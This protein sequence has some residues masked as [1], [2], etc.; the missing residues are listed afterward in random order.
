MRFLINLFL[1]NIY[2][3]TYSN[4]ISLSYGTFDVYL[5]EPLE[6]AEAIDACTVMDG[7]LPR[8]N[9]EHDFEIIGSLYSQY[10]FVVTWVK[11]IVV[12]LNK[13]IFKSIRYLLWT[14]L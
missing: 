12:C 14:A 3:Q 8:F 2:C 10:D 5:M 9:D 7:R 1:N 6:M 4:T 11:L 13:N